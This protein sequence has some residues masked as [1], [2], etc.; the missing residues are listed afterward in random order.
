MQC[1]IFNR[2]T[3]D[4]EPQ[5]HISRD[6]EEMV[7]GGM[8]SVLCHATLCSPPIATS[9]FPRDA[10]R[11]FPQ[12]LAYGYDRLGVRFNTASRSPSHAACH[13]RGNSP[14]HHPPPSR[15]PRSGSD[16]HG[17]AAPLRHRPHHLASLPRP[18]RGGADDPISVLRTIDPSIPGADPRGGLPSQARPPGLG[19]RPDSPRVAPGRR[20][21]R[22]PLDSLAPAGLSPGRG[23]PASLAPTS[24]IDHD[25]SPGAPRSLAGRRRG[26]GP[27]GHGRV[28]Q[29]DD[30]HRRIHRGAAGRRAFPPPSGRPSRPAR[31]ASCSATPS[32]DGGCPAG[33]GS[34]TAIPGG[35]TSGCRPTSPCG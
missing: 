5:T 26:E 23:P 34:T 14:G 33:F 11:S 29:L 28:G 27:P 13:R 32:A 16:R 22:G 15:W 2:F 9:C 17:T 6:D 21:G 25:P 10:T 12:G 1:N 7:L 19:S 8:L 31:A 3:P 20:G 30:H 4:E 18:G 24:P 35:S